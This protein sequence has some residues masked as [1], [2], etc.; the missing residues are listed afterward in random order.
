[1]EDENKID[2]LFGE[3]L[4]EGNSIPSDV[5]WNAIQNKMAMA[6]PKS[7]RLVPIPFFW[8]SAALVS[9]VIL[10]TAGFYMLQLKQEN[11]EL[12]RSIA[13]QKLHFDNQIKEI[14]QNH[15]RTMEQLEKQK[16]PDNQ[17]L[18]SANEKANYNSG[19]L[20][21]VKTVPRSVSHRTKR[22]DVLWDT[23]HGTGNS[24][25]KSRNVEPRSVAQRPKSIDHTD[26]VWKTNHGRNEL[27]RNGSN[28]GDGSRNIVRNNSNNGINNS[29]SG[30]E[31]LN[32]N[33]ISNAAVGNE[34]KD[35]GNLIT[36]NR[37]VSSKLAKVDSVKKELSDSSKVSNKTE[38]PI[39]KKAP[40]LFGL[41]IAIGFYLSPE[42]ASRSV[43]F[44]SSS[45]EEVKNYKQNDKSK[46]G[47]GAGLSLELKLPHNYFFRTGISYWNVGERNTSEYSISKLDTTYRTDNS[48]K[49]IRPDGTV[50]WVTGDTIGRVETSVNAFPGQ[51]YG[52]FAISEIKESVSNFT[53]TVQNNY[54]YMGVPLVFGMRLGRSRLHAGLYS[55]VIANVLVSSNRAVYSIYYDPESP[56]KYK[57][58]Y[59]Q[60][61]RFSFVY[62][63]GIDFE[64]Q[65]APN[66]SLTLSP[67][68]KYSLTSLYKNEP[69]VK[70]L[71]YSVGLLVGCN[72]SF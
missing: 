59:R 17:L 62:W 56:E 18:T 65:L 9:G 10:G 12:K 66:W 11:T 63:G 35:Q 3:R 68:I 4:G 47:F 37:A 16:N 21:S 32:E 27:Q 36:Q 26:D 7:K 67:N 29:E 38:I 57:Q 15:F 44:N 46:F 42:M 19:S 70:Q 13:V 20:F 31:N 22:V 5:A 50:S 6:Q 69:E 1:M 24:N 61:S 30:I 52:V 53:S 64:F 58:S 45:T 8:F 72:Y 39:K 40:T 28:Q 54:H 14:E 33:Q 25:T 23:E 34:S 71:P 51:K 60:L 2:R 43:N 55:G 41:P 49:V 48:L